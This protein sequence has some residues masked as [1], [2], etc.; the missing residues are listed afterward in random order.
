MPVSLVATVRNEEATVADLLDSILAQTRRPDEVVINDCGCT[1]GTMAIVE[2]YRGRLPLRTTSGGRNI[3]Q[4]RNTAI[5]AAS[6]PFIACTDAGLRLDE[7]W[8][9][10][11]V[12]PLERGQADLVA[13][14]FRADPRSPFERVLGAVAYPR[15]SEIDPE[16]FLPAGQS[17]AFTRALWEAVGGFPEALPYCEDLVFTRQALA[18]GF[19]KT[20]LPQAIVHFRPRPSLAAFFRQY[21]NYAYGD[22]L[23]NLWPRRHAL[24]YGSYAL[25]LGLLV[26]GRWWPPLWAVLGL[27][28]LAYLLPFYRRLGP[29]WGEL[30]P[31]W[32]VAAFFLVPL[33]RL[34]GDVAKMV[35][36][37]PGIWRRLS[38]RCCWLRPERT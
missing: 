37:P 8:L 28:G 1:D 24:R 15:L 29:V 13:G 7:R 21:R 33:I 27:A 4:G 16:K 5:R 38:H 12:A 31:L 19:R 23:A 34:S 17:M 9:E 14:F 10:E 11:V 36:Y 3:P 25:G 18:L 6:G 26:A 30:P 22:G 32:A 2:Q 35:G 20:F